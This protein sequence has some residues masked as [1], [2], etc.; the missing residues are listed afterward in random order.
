MEA[1]SKLN[2]VAYG[3]ARRTLIYPAQIPLFHVLVLG[4]VMRS[5]G[6]CY[7]SLRL[8]RLVIVDRT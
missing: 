3:G 7:T 8:L 2:K 6:Y 1:K 5:L 4:E